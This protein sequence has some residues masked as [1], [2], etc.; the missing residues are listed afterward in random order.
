MRRAPPRSATRSARTAS[1]PLRAWHRCPLRKSRISGSRVR[2]PPTPHGGDRGLISRRV[3]LLPCVKANASV[4]LTNRLSVF[5]HTESRLPTILRRA[6]AS[7]DSS[8]IV[9]RLLVR[10]T[11]SVMRRSLTYFTRLST[12]V[13]PEPSASWFLASF[14]SLALKMWKPCPILSACRSR[15]ACHIDSGP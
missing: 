3:L 14:T 1:C 4:L 12:N 5:R 10:Q 6:W 7:R 9:L 13:F 2:A 8:G 11:S 15:P